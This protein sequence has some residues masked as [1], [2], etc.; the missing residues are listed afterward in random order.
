MNDRVNSL[1]FTHRYL[2]PSDPGTKD[3]LLL[4]HGT[5]GDE[6]DLLDVGQMLWPEAG[7]LSPRGKVMENGM[8]RFFRRLAEGVFDVDDLIRRTDELAEFVGAAA[9][10][11]RFDPQRVVAVGYSNGANIAAST[12]LLRSIILSKAIL[13]HPM[14]PLVP[15]SLPDL[16]GRAVFIGAGRRDPIAVPDQSEQ[17]A[18]LLARTGADVT[19]HWENGGHALARGEVEAAREWLR[20]LA[21]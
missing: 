5:G 11:Y 9:A 18:Q 12:L 13:F 21:S 14:V 8:A 4:L 6:N 1:G 16:N 19:I 17:L 15:E 7:R 10:L 2:A 3:T 20:Q